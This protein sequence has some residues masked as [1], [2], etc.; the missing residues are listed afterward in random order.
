[1][2]DS[3]G[4][5][6]F[7]KYYT[8]TATEE[9]IAELMYWISLDGNEEKVKSFM[10]EHWAEFH[11]IPP[12]SA[13]EGRRMLQ[14]IL[15]RQDVPEKEMERRSYRWIAVAASLAVIA[16]L[17]L[18][19]ISIQQDRHRAR[20]IFPGGNRATL[21]LANGHVIVLGDA[22]KGELARQ[23][24]ARIVKLDSGRLLY[25]LSTS[26]TDGQARE[27]A[28]ALYNTV[29]TPRSGQYT[30]MLP[31]GSKVWLNA[32]SSL[33]FPTVFGSG[34]RKVAV[35]GE[36]Y[37]EIKPDAT[38]PFKVEIFSET[39]KGM[40]TVQVL[41]THFNINAY[42]D[43]A[44]VKTTLVEGAIKVINGNV[45]KLLQPG[46][47]AR[48]KQGRDEIAVQQVNAG[49]I[50]AWKDGFF[51]FNG[52]DIAAI[53]Q[54]IARW[55]DVKVSYEDGHIPQGHYTGVISRQSP[56]SEVLKILEMGGFYFTI[57]G[58]EIIVH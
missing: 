56:L 20:D 52:D 58:R 38:R 50:V 44:M 45:E 33:R 9:E 29:E 24:R 1:M 13:P 39:G 37:F 42:L 5:Y 53:M 55:Y 18:F 51:Q 35:K 47:Q 31:D 25:A 28:T 8:Q 54:Q 6:L 41:G 12:E 3:R 17:S 19:I 14:H 30:V 4:K 27:H 26:P 7:R 10:D 16:V 49:G 23:G 32:S 57:K 11:Y 15:K 48:M 22:Q 2:S 36:A 34:G 43:S 40:G 21:T 46:E